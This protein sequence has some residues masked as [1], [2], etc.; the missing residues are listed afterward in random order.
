MGGDGLQASASRQCSNQPMPVFTPVVGNPAT[1]SPT[2]ISVWNRLG[3]IIVEGIG[4]VGSLSNWIFC[5]LIRKK[6]KS[7]WF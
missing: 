1:R 6:G 4:A 2:I 3:I 5:F 7:Q